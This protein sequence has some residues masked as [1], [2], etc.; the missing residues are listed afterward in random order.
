MMPSLSIG[1]FFSRNTHRIALAG[2]RGYYSSMAMAHISPG[3]FCISASS[4]I[5]SLL[6]SLHI[7]RISFSLSMVAHSAP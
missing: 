5:S 6:S 1:F 2:D 7:L 3:S 4:G